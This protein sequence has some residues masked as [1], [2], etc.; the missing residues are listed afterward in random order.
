MTGLDDFAHR[1]RPAHGEPEG[2]LVLFHGRGTSEDDLFPL[3]DLL[4]PEARL[5][6]ITP[7]G[8][9]ELGGGAHW[10]IVREVG[11]PDPATF[12]PTYSALA[13]WVDG[14]PEALGVSGERIVLGGFSQGAVMTHALTLGKGRPSPAAAIALSG[15]I[16]EVEGFE[17]DLESRR[18]LPVAIGHGTFDPVIPVDFGRAAKQ[19]LEAAGLDVVYR[20]SPMAH[21]VDPA[22]L[23][24]LRPWLAAAIIPSPSGRPD[25]RAAG[26]P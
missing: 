15:F 5:V 11:Y 3:L 14:L 18:G 10:Y 7:R 16:P 17:L 6:G 21:S 23:E 24:E 13:D 4:D 8:P 20:E 9:L 2:A 19:R 25:S 26:G 22:F 12:F 1:L